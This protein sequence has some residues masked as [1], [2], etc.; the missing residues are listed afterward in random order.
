MKKI[1]A[2]VMAMCFITATSIASIP[3][4]QGSAPVVKLTVNP[5]TVH[6]G[7]EYTITIEVISTTGLLT[8]NLNAAGDIIGVHVISGKLVYT[9]TVKAPAATGMYTVT[10][11]AKDG[12]GSCTLTCP[13]CVN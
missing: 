5:S 8:L 6:P 1:I 12:G 3:Q 10:L 2:L 7:E 9:L 13:L 11:T 4:V